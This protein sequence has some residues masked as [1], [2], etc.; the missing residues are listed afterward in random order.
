[1]EVAVWVTPIDAVTADVAKVLV[2]PARHVVASLRLN[3][4][5]ATLRARLR[6]TRSHVLVQSR[7]TLLVV[8]TPLIVL[9]TCHALMPVNLAFHAAVVA[10]ARARELAKPS[11]QLSG[12]HTIYGGRTNYVEDKKQKLSY[13]HI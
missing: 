7:I 13:K 5:G 8:F 10:A 9:V 1:M 6:P 4:P 11:D 2:A 12:P 3:H